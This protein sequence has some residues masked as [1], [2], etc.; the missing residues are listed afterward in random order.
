MIRTSCFSQKGIQK[1]ESTCTLN[2]ACGTD[3]HK[4]SYH[5]NINLRKFNAGKSTTRSSKSGPQYGSVDKELDWLAPKKLKLY[6]KW[7]AFVVNYFHDVR[8]GRNETVTCEGISCALAPEML[9]PAYRHA[10]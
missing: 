8:F 3:C 7:F 9:T 6:R 4:I 5:L 10:R 2:S 1:E